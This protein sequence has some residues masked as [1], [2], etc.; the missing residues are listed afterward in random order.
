[1]VIKYLFEKEEMLK[2]RVLIEY[3]GTEIMLVDQLTK[4]L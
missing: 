2:Y 3:I 4:G 1:M